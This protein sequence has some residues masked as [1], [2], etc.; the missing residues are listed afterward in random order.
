MQV[1]RFE[2]RTPQK[3][4]KKTTSKTIVMMWHTR[5]VLD[6]GSTRSQALKSFSLI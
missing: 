4:R 5:F 1:A 6:V 3:R 2:S